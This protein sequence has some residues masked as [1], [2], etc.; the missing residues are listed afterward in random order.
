M[1]EEV[2]RNGGK[3]D[4]WTDY[5]S[6]ERWNNAFKTC[7]IDPAFYAERERGKDELMPWDIIDIGV[8]REHLWHEREMC[9]QSELSPDCREKCLGC[10]AN[11]LIGGACNG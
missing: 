2:W 9:Y 11:K 10:G 7:G 5:F 4:A 1:I 3:L 8:R 6:Y